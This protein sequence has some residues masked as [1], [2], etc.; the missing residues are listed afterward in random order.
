MKLSILKQAREDVELYQARYEVGRG[1]GGEAEGVL[2]HPAASLWRKMTGKQQVSKA[3]NPI[4]ACGRY[5]PSVGEDKV[6]NWV[7]SN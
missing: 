2:T 4:S 7:T 6:S 5:C 3:R 1:G